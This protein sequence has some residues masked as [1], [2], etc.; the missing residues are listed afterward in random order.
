[1]PNYTFKHPDKDEYEEVFFHMNDEPKSF[2]DEDGVE[3]QRIFSLPEL[4]TSGGI[5]P[6][7]N[8]DFVN[9]TADQKGSYGD[10]LDRSSELSEKR[11]QERDGIDP[12]K[13]K[14][15]DNYAKKRGG[16]RHTKE[17]KEKG[18]ENKNIKIEY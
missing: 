15:Y 3:W 7:N 6:W 5:D 1:M 13:Q 8:A 11:A 4:N 10:L 17:T 14:Y 2:T 18:F 12:V 9:K 16:A